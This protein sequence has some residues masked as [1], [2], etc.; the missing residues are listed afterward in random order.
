MAKESF[1]I[2]EDI[3]ELLTEDFFIPYQQACDEAYFQLSLLNLELFQEL[4]RNVVHFMKKRVK[5]PYSIYKKMKTEKLPIS[6]IEDIAGIRVVVHNK[7]D[8]YTLRNKIKSNKFFKVIRIDNMIEKSKDDGY[9]S[10]HVIT[11]NTIGE[12]TENEIK[13]LCEIQIRSIAEDL[14]ATL[15][16][17]EIYKDIE[18][19]EKL[20]KKMIELSNLLDGADSFAET[21]IEQIE[22][23]KKK[24]KIPKTY[25]YY[26]SGAQY[27]YP[28]G[29]IWE[30]PLLLKYKPLK[31]KEVKL[32]P[33]KIKEVKLKPLKI[34]EPVFREDKN[35]RK[36][37]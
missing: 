10:L 20:R 24:G 4:G 37:K 22:E 19:P 1:R 29:A 32:K 34:K 2:N 30:K 5:A 16:H 26:P 11:E 18:L 6:K 15:S 9:R 14:W 25:E 17:R 31:I 36:K 12:N 28:S 33:L 13:V 21:L 3:K 8:V 7:K 23:E 27:Y 35:K